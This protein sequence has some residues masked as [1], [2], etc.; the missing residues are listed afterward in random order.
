[1][2]RLTGFITGDGYFRIVA[3][4]TKELSNY[5]R[6]L[7]QLSYPVVNALSRFVTGAALLSSNLKGNDTLGVYLNCSGPLTGIRVEVNALGQMKAF[8]IQSQAGIDEVD[9]SYVMPLQQL[10]GKGTLTVTK[11]METGR[12]PFTGA[13]QVEGDRLAIGFSRYLMDSEQVHSAVLISNF[14]TTD[15]HATAS[16]GILV[17]AFPGVEEENL[18]EIEG[19]I[20]GFP[21]FSD[22]I[23]EVENIEDAV[24]MLFSRYK[25]ARLFSR[26]LEF[27]CS[28]SREKVIRVLKSLSEDDL[29]DVRQGDGS[30]L[31]TC[32]YCKTEYT[33]HPD[34]LRQ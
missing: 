1:M 23:M 22:V 16:A 26:S 21:P 19:E 15:G 27:H 10:I 32:D 20:K 17:Q 4:E 5:L 7:H 29:K 18:K 11:F 6:S 13:V 2:D 28:C 25:P 31:V 3:A 9:P 34:E 12:T 33:V 8:A 14:L 30:F 24:Q